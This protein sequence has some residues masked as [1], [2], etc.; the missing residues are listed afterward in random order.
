MTWPQVHFKSINGR[1]SPPGIKVG[2]KKAHNGLRNDPSSEP[3]M[4]KTNKL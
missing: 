4:D 2:T 1:Q 3:V